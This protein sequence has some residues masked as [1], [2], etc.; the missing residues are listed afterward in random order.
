[1]RAFLRAYWRIS[2]TGNTVGTHQ[3]IKSATIDLATPL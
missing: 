3:S 2:P 1:M